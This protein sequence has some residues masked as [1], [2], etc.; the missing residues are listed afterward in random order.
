MKQGD[1]LCLSRVKVFFFRAGHRL[2]AFLHS[3]FFLFISEKNR[4]VDVNGL[5]HKWQK[6]IDIK[7]TFV[8]PKTKKLYK[9]KLD[10]LR[11]IETSV[12]SCCIAFP[13]G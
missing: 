12:W 1:S 11:R 7:R 6:I 10:M 2:T 8:V 13:F 3:F 9:L 5:S 4:S